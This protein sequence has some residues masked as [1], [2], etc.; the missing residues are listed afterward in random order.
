MTNLTEPASDNTSSKTWQALFNQGVEQLAASGL[1]AVGDAPESDV[2][3]LLVA[4]SG[5]ELDELLKI[6]HQP[7]DARSAA[8]FEAMLGECLTGRP[9]QY[10]LGGWGFRSLDLY[11]DE[12]VLIPRPETECL[13]EVAMLEL[14]RRR[15]MLSQQPASSAPSGTQ[16]SSAPPAPH[17]KLRVADL[18]CGSGAIGLSIAAELTDVEVFCCDISHDTL[19]VTRA[20]LAGLGMAASPVYLGQGSWYEG[21]K[22]ATQL[23]GDETTT[24]VDLIC[25]NPPYI[26]NSE[27]LP[28]SVHNFE[29]TEALYAGE[30]GTEAIAELLEGIPKWLL[31]GGSF[32]CEIAPAQAGFASRLAQEA[33]LAEVKITSD[34]AGRER[35]LRARKPT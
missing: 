25:S 12:R 32:V 15:K 30:T 8:Q 24:A 10:V 6:W 31:P 2:R 3:R 29:P 23:V 27:T 4:A 20:N 18:G 16:A 17:R 1:E 26:A 14:A 13:V 7:A 9:L 33:G 5:L 19:A 28:P 11:L 34:L 21:L 22:Q 35:V